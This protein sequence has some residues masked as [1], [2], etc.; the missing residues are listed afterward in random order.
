MIENWGI[1][2]MKLDRQDHYGKKDSNK[3]G[4]YR[5]VA[6]EALTERYGSDP[7]IDRSKSGD[8][9]LIYDDGF[10]N[11]IKEQNK[12]IL[13]ATLGDYYDSLVADWKDPRGHKFR[14]DGVIT[15]VC[16][17][18]PGIDDE[19]WKKMTKK[20]KEVF[21]KHSID[22]F[23]EC[24]GDKKDRIVVD[25][26]VIHEDEGNFHIHIFF[27]DMDFSLGDKLGLP[28]KEELH[29]GAFITYMKEQGYDLKPHESGITDDEQK[30]IKELKQQIKE[31]P[32]NENLQTDLTNLRRSIKKRKGGLTSAKYKADKQAKKIIEQ[33]QMQADK[34]R[35]E[36]MKEVEQLKQVAEQERIEI[37][38]QAQAIK[39]QLISEGKQE[40]AAAYKKS[41][42]IIADAQDEKNRLI[43]EGRQEKEKLISEGKQVR[44]AFKANPSDKF[45]K[46][47][48]LL[49]S[50]KD[51]H[52]SDK[53]LSDL[54][55]DLENQNSMGFNQ[56]EPYAAFYEQIRMEQEIHKKPTL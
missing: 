8:N 37:F 25:C 15:G 24:F 16:I 23:V 27:H 50:T 2:I 6:Q 42:Q 10:G 41:D 35:E 45:R 48:N 33:A 26:A 4:N 12:S 9:L 47:I 18:K 34:I 7:D 5:A 3:K 31:D 46:I 30:R 19:D 40:K 17:I 28:F 55:R 36:A 13:G 43:S 38:R 53:Q 29:R 39:E 44:N 21:L 52:P 20:E 1:T 54:S 56:P 51:N 32:E 14:K 49:G 11:Y 22:G